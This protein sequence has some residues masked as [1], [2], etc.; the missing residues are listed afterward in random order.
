MKKKAVEIIKGMVGTNLDKLYWVSDTSPPKNM[1]KSFY[2]NI[3]NVC[4]R[5]YPGSRIR[6]FLSR[7]RSPQHC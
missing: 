2:F 3:D 6:T 1:A 7:L 5:S 4:S